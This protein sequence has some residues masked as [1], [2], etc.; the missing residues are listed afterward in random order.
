VPKVREF[1]QFFVK[2]ILVDIYWIIYRNQQDHICVVMVLDLEIFRAEKGGN[3]E[4]VRESQRKRFK[5]VGLVD[6][7]IEAD[8]EWRKC[9]Y[10][11]YPRLYVQVT[12]LYICTYFVF[13]QVDF[14]PMSSID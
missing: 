14:V 11:Y 12:Y 7:V 8:N 3:P 10:L 2:Y 6:K 5:D 4:L 13:S 9:K 1:F